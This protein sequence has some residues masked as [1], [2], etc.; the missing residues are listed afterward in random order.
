MSGCLTP[1]S[2]VRAGQVPLAIRRARSKSM[3]SSPRIKVVTRPRCDVTRRSVQVVGCMTK[4][5]FAT[6]ARRS[7]RPS[8]DVVSRHLRAKPSAGLLG[9]VGGVEPGYLPVLGRACNYNRRH[10]ITDQIVDH[11]ITRDTGPKLLSVNC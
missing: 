6:E 2:A 7:R 11:T 9:A 1:G 3:A 10:R 4:T 5:R 8:R